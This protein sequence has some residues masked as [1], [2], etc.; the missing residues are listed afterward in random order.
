VAFG[1]LQEAFV[2]YSEMAAWRRH[3]DTLFGVVGQRST[4][5]E[6]PLEFY[7]F[8]HE[9][10]KRES[11]ERLLEVMAGSPDYE[12][13]TKLTQAELASIHAERITNVVL[14]S[15]SNQSRALQRPGGGAVSA[16]Y[17]ERP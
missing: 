4:K 3:P 11:K 8:V 17:P 16:A 15:E 1:N 12:R 6:T 2:R 9:S 13:L 5:A 14:A 7:D 10:F